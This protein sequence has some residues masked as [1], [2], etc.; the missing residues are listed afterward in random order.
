MTRTSRQQAVHIFPTIGCAFTFGR[1]T[2]ILLAGLGVLTMEPFLAII[3]FLPHAIR[4]VGCVG[5]FPRLISH[6]VCHPRSVTFQC[7]FPW[8]S[9][10]RGSLRV[11]VQTVEATMTQ[12]GLS[13]DELSG[14][15]T[16]GIRA[17]GSRVLNTG[18]ILVCET[19]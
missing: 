18:R 14:R 9:A 5:G 4:T 11:E 12:Y 19:E 17:L 8:L 15:N 3:V 7:K 2:C 1:Y 13:A 10:N 6:H 16:S